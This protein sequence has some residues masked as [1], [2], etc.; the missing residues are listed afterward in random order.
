MGTE[1]TAEVTFTAGKVAGWSWMTAT[2]STDD[3]VYHTH[4]HFETDSPQ[5]CVVAALAGIVANL[6][7]SIVKKEHLRVAKTHFI[8]SMNQMM[9]GL[10]A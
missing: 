3:E 9:E 6:L 8:V 10:D 1:G 2:V 4:F 5:D 7:A